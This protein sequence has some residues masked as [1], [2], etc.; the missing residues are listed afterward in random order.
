MN[1]L[2]NFRAFL[3][4]RHNVRAHF[5]Q[6]CAN[7]S[8]QAFGLFLGIWLARLLQPEDF[9]SFAYSSALVGL[10][11]LP[12]SLS[13]AGQIVPELNKNPLILTDALHFTW[14]MLPL[15]LLVAAL[16][17]LALG[18]L[19]GWQ[20]FAVSLFLSFPMVFSDFI[21]VPRAV[22]EA[23]RKFQFNFFDSIVTFLVVGVPGTLLAWSG[24]GVW[25]LVIPAIPL[26][27]VQMAMFAYFSK[28]NLSPSA[29]KSGINYSKNIW[30]F[31]FFNA[32]E[33]LLS[34]ADKFVLGKTCSLPEVG[35][36]NRALNYGPVSARLLGSLVSNPTVAALANETDKKS[37]K[38]IILKSGILLVSGGIL[39]FIVLFY[40]SKSL[41]PWVF[42][43]QWRNSIPVFEAVAPMSLVMA[44]TN[45][46]IA[47]AI[48]K[49]MYQEVAISRLAG[50]IFFL[51]IS[52]FFLPK[53]NP[54]V[55]AILLQVAIL[56]QLPS[57]LFIWKY[58]IIKSG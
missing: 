35:D 58:N 31:W 53:M 23:R 39:N 6:S 34:R 41:V 12:V 48:S 37:R 14:R 9:G 19:Q 54:L 47:V 7:Y 51:V 49:G 45:L 21:S 26:T 24:A 44:V 17:C 29:K 40:F 56:F 4:R 10:C 15:K 16:F 43:E 18:F 20:G 33:Q 22:L 25:A 55:M 57:L 27:V 1:L 52:L 11:L 2:T 13:L 3:A 32:G 42:G 28:V 38:R 5:W 46:P 30:S 36:Y 8:Q 50:A